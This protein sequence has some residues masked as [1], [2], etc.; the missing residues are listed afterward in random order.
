M[1]VLITLKR[2]QMLALQAKASKTRH[3]MESRDVIMLK[4]EEE[5]EVAKASCEDLEVTQ[6]K[7]L[8]EISIKNKRIEEVQRL[9]C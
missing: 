2:V 5:L 3:G 1:S 6:R 9:D 8:A 7:F 4:L